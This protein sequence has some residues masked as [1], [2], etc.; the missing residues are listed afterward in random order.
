M[1]S[2]AETARLVTAAELLA[3]ARRE[4]GRIVAEAEEVYARRQEE[5]Y[6]E[7]LAEG[8]LAQAEKMMETT[9]AAV[10]YLEALESTIVRVVADSVRKVAGNLD[11]GNLIV[12]I[13]HKALESVRGQQRALIRLSPEDEKRARSRLEET[14]GASLGQTGWLEIKADPRL[15]RGDCLLESELGVVDAGLETQLRV[16]EEALKSRVRGSGGVGE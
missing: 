1:L 9:L 13:V 2:A 3:E 15:K 11:P 14:L 16:I 10:E 6:Q 8:R 4:A 5:G 7:G 12:N